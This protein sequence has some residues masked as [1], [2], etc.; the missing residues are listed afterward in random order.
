MAKAFEGIKVVDFSQVLAGPF[1]TQQLALQGAG[2]IKI[3]QRGTGDQAR[4]MM[5][6][7]GP[8]RDHG[9]GAIFLCVNAGK[10]SI[11]LDLTKENG[12]AVAH[13]LMTGA[14]VIVE[15]YRTGVARKLDV[16]YERART[17]NPAI[18]YCAI[19]AYG[20]ARTMATVPARTRVA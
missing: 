2:V 13:R 1:A 5:A 9:M 18:V 16:H 20:Q 8:I 11:T 14:D 17:L 3:E 7:E 6:P 19:T 12:R 10:R 4:A 15:S